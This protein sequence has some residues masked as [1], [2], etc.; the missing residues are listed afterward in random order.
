MTFAAF[1]ANVAQTICTKLYPS[2]RAMVW[3]CICKQKTEPILILEDTI[4]ATTVAEL[5]ETIEKFG[6]GKLRLNT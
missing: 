4:N 1:D 6:M 5:K 3:G 2:N